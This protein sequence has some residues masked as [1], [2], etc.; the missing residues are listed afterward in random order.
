MK[1][2]IAAAP[3]ALIVALI[4]A[5]AIVALIACSSETE[6]DEPQPAS[7]QTDATDTP[8]FTC[9]PGDGPMQWDSPP[10]MAI[11]ASKKYTAVFEMEK[12]VSFDIELYADK[13]P[14]T[15]NSFAF[16]ACQGFY[17]GVT[18]HRV[19]PGFM[20]QGGDPTGTGT[21]GPGY[22]IANE[23]HPDARH[24]SPGIISTANRGG[25]A[26]NGSQ[27]FITFV[28]T[29]ALD[30]HGKDC[31]QP[32]V[33]CHSVFGKVSS[34]MDVVNA[35]SPRDPGTATTPGDA[36]KTIRIIEE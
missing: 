26:T 2:L 3:K 35:I 21:G 33:S 20:A 29:P 1:Q 10:A 22:N 36:I 34:G 5:F 28:P 13:A 27:F 15:V 17:D 31:S 11:D 6:P 12:G 32:G 8:A 16:L 4:G 24:D 23:I 19:I 9:Q 25:T 18:F 14:N 7:S 30:G